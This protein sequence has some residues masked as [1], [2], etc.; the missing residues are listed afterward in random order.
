MNTPTH[1]RWPDDYKSWTGTIQELA[2]TA[3]QVLQALEPDVKA[4]NLRLLRYYQQSGV[5]G[6]GRKEGSQAIFGFE[7]LERV[8][9]AKGLV[10]Q[11]WTLDQAVS[12]MDT[13]PAPVSSLLYG[14]PTA[15]L[16]GTLPVPPVSPLAASAEPASAQDVVARLMARSTLGAS[17]SSHS[18][19]ALG[20]SSTPTLATANAIVRSVSPK[21]AAPAPV[22]TPMQAIQPA[23]WMTV[24]LD[25]AAAR[26]ASPAD[27]Q[28]AVDALLSALRTLS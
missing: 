27:R 15:S 6:R 12:L 26:R 1:P 20:M 28:A 16:S 14:S 21:M 18:S 10:K 17:A 3:T 22:A 13:H 8:V 19:G 4:P 24:Y 11:N 9:A 5:M 7:D 2:D 23:P 25:E